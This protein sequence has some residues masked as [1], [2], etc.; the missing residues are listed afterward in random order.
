MDNWRSSLDYAD[1]SLPGGYG[2]VIRLG[3]GTFEANR[4]LHD[5][6]ITTE[7][8]LYLRHST[9]SNVLVIQ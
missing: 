3:F 9:N 6:F 1:S 5:L 4:W 8:D 2:N 7:G